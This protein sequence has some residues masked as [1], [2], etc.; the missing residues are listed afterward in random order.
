[1]CPADELDAI[2]EVINDAANAY[3]GAI[4]E[5]CW[6]Q[7]Y[8]PSAELAEDVEQGV[9]FVGAYHGDCLLA[10]MGLQTVGDVA[11]IR[12]AYTRTAHQHRGLGTRL[13]ERLRGQTQDPLLVGTWRAAE[14]AV[15]FYESRGFRLLNARHSDTLLRRYWRI[16]ALQRRHSVALADSRW[17]ARAPAGRAR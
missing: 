3:R 9:A 17:F 12:H 6:S 14:W 15:R 1:M 10:V 7:P 5:Q 11:L 2:V 13:L 16:S 4:P 8:M